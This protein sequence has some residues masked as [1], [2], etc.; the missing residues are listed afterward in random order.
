[1]HVSRIIVSPGTNRIHGYVLS[2]TFHGP[3]KLFVDIILCGTAP[4]GANAH[5]HQ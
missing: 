5:E 4:G 2:L 1:M 3:L